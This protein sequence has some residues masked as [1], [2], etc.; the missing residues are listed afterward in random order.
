MTETKTYSYHAWVSLDAVP[1]WLAKGWIAQDSLDGTHHGIW[2]C[3]LIWPFLKEP[4]Y[5]ASAN[6]GL[7]D[8]MKEIIEKP[9]SE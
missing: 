9:K 5:P 1:S 8:S 4:E 6:P 3:H 7:V 2:S